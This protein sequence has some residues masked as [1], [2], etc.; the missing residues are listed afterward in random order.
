MKPP[1]EFRPDTN[2]SAK[3]LAKSAAPPKLA[4]PTDYDLLAERLQA[5]EAELV[6][7]RAL[8]A[9]QQ[10]RFRAAKKGKLDQ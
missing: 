8:K 4:A 9:A 1:I 6:R 2:R 7:R 3:Q 5:A 10:R